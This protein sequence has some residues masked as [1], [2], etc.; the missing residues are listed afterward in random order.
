MARRLTDWLSYYIQYA[1]NTESPELFDYWT[2]VAVLAGTLSRKARMKWPPETIYPNHYIILVAPSGK[3]RKGVAMN[4][5]QELFKTLNESEEIYP[6]SSDALTKERLIQAIANSISDWV[7]K[8]TGK[9]Q[10]QCSLMTFS[11]EFAI[12]LGQS[13]IG[14]LATLTDLYDCHD[15]WRY[16]TKNGTHDI[17]K[18]LC[19]NILAATAPDWF[20]SILPI[21]AIGGGFTAR[22][23]FV[24]EESRKTIPIPKESEEV[25]VLRRHLIHDLKEIALISGEYNFDEEALALYAQWYTQQSNDADKGKYP[26]KDPRFI[27]YSERRPTQIKKLCMVLSAA[28]SDSMII[29]GQDFLRA[30]TALERVEKDMP[31][32]FGGLGA[33]PTAKITYHILNS[34]KR[35]K[36]VSRSD[37]LNNF[38]QDIGTTSALT[39][40]EGTLK[41][42]GKIRVEIIDG[43]EIY[44]WIGSN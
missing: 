11:K 37:I 6:I 18:N 9:I 29:T 26:I 17:I 12:F 5:G 39:E 35:F 13:N 16:E 40:I 32:V 36:R 21:E 2:G 38:Y 23:I 15:V 1:Q 43:E 41:K 44:F 34:I 30:R 4:L 25:V 22:I 20:N 14:M 19:Y 10:L 3:A 28:Q 33:S 42:M 7:D 31:L 24:W 8:T 27:A